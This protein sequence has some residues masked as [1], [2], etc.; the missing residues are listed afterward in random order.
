MKGNVLVGQ[1]GGPTAVINSSLAGVFKTAMDRG[2]KNVYGMRYGIQGFLDEQYVNMADYVKNELD[3]ELLK[4]TPSAFLGTCRYKLPAI[5][6]DKA[7]YERIF[8]LLDKMDIEVFIYIGGNDSMDTIK[9]L[10]DYAILTG[11]TQRFI[12]CPKTID[13]DLAL[14]DHTPGYGSAAKYIGTSTKEVI[15]DCSGFSYKKKNVTIIEIMGRNAGWLTGAAALSKAEDCDGPDLIYL[16]EIPFDVDKFTTKVEKLLKQ[17]D[18]VVVAVSEGIHTKDGKYIC[19]FSAGSETKDAF[20]HIQMTGTAAYLANHIHEKIGCK[21]R[22]V[23][24]SSLQRSA[25]HL[26]S[27]IDINEAFM[28]GGAA[29]KAADEGIS[30]VMVVIDRLS[31]DPY[32]STTGVYDVHRIANGEKLV[33]REWINKD[34][35]YVTDEFISYLRPL[36][37][38]DYAPMMVDGLPRHLTM[39]TKGYKDLY[40]VFVD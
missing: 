25:S 18:V 22:S 38:G 12:G 20:G 23:E 31:D 26:A 17:K 29:I 6:E 19:E 13:N 3:L 34:G 21:T 7:V 27:R 40:K 9:K 14:T 11:A 37:Q 4:R 30:G 39:N 8:E 32:Q 28:V 33:P 24:F 35:D 10:S 15:R 16:P 5:H 36:I 1:S 2:F